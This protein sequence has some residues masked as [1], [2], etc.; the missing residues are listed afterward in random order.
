VA[1][2]CLDSP[3]IRCGPKQWLEFSSIRLG[4]LH[5][6]A[7]VPGS[8]WWPRRLRRGSHRPVCEGLRLLT[9]KV[10]LDSNPA[11]K[12]HSGLTGKFGRNR[13]RALLLVHRFRLT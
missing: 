11:R 4:A 10:R 12:G 5:A 13:V 9:F 3:S 8:V 7:L 1:Y 2:Q 6:L